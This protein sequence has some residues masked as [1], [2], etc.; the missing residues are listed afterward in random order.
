MPSLVRLSCPLILA[1]ESPRRKALLEQIGVSFNIQASS[2][3]ETVSE[4]MPPPTIAKRLAL[5][6]VQPV[7]AKN[8]SALVLAADTVVAHEGEILG[9][10]DTP[11]HARQMLQ[12]LSATTHTVYT[13]MALLHSETQRET[14]I[15]EDTDVV[16]A[17]LTE[18][19]IS[20][21]VATRSPMDKAGGYGIQDHTGPLLVEQI[22]GDY[23]NVVGLPLH[24][25]YRVLHQK[26]ED[27]MG[28]PDP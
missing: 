19:E 24:R 12:R 5:R 22:E 23:Y 1:S 14:S 15:V 25:F 7:A 11:G 9:K 8:P 27:L 4:P 10:P 6:K 17:N 13:G 2:A 18:E 20:A 28:T 21:Y 3:D 26:Y 16:F